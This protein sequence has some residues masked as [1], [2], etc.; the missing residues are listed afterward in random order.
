MTRLT[1]LTDS[2]E[3]EL[4]YVKN[5][6]PSRKE[7]KDHN[8]KRESEKSHLGIYEGCKLLE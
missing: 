6:T 2:F 7:K 3:Y 1:T 8:H 5:P 4:I